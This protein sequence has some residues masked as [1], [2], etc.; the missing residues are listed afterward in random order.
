MTGAP[1]DD[2]GDEGLGTLVS[3]STLGLAVILAVG[4][5]V[6]LW[7]AKNLSPH[8]DEPA[9]LLAAKMVAEHGWPQLPSGAPYFQGATLSYILA[10]IILL[11]HTDLNYFR[12]LR[13]VPVGFGVLTIY[14]VFR[15]AMVMTKRAWIALTVA[16][17]IAIDPLSVEWSAHV[18]MYAP[19]E[20]LAVVLTMLFYQAMIIDPSRRLLVGIVLVFW[21]GIFTQIA[22]ALFLPP[23][24]L[25]AFWVYGKRLWRDRKDVL[26]AGT[27][28]CFAPLAFTLLNRLG[29]Y[30]G[31]STRSGPFSFVGDHLIEFDRIL[32]PN[33][34]VWESLFARGNLVSIMPFVFAFATGLLISGVYLFQRSGEGAREDR[35]GVTALLLFNW[36]SIGLV[37]GFTIQGQ[38][39]YL[40]HIQPLSL[41]LFVL[42][43][44]ELIKAARGSSLKTARG[45]ALRLSAVALVLLQFLNLGAG[46]NFLHGHPVIDVDYVAAALYVKEHR[47]PDQPVISALAQVT[48]TSLGSTDNVYFL[49]GDTGR[50][51][52]TR[53]TYLQPDGSLADFWLGVPA[54]VGTASLC[55][56]FYQHPGAWILVDATRLSVSWGFAGDM[57]AVI[58]GAGIVRF[59]GD[60]YTYAMQVKHESKWNSAASKICETALGVAPA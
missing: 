44:R 48:Y 3:W 5:I 54:I 38:P 27:I 26:V 29:P 25:T 32:D 33:L 45:A 23:M 47:T 18:R 13:L 31:A 11:A 12:M 15:L 41:L 46:L 42:G 34:S 58:R 24:L 17:M 20:M 10:P 40:I 43:A 37:A 56:V 16:A 8:V 22:I 1:V 49:S 28:C 35:I 39:R 50:D 19:L 30:H 60:R 51:R 14:F 7:A 53:Y 57:A 52:A 21:A 36:F 6:R 9:S 2:A 4:L 55:S 59:T